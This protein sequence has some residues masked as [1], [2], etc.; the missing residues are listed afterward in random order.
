VAEEI[1]ALG[2]GFSAQSG[3]NSYGLQGS[4]LS[5]DLERGLGFFSELLWRP[6]LHEDDVARE[7]ALQL[8]DLRTRDDHPAGVAISLF[9]EGLYT[10]HPYRLEQEGTT[11][12]VASLESAQLRAH[13]ERHYGTAGLVIAAAGDVDP[14]QLRTLLEP[15]LAAARAGAAVGDDPPHDPP[16]PGVVQRHRSLPRRQAHLVYGFRGTTLD[17]PDRA[18]A[19]LLAAVLGGQGGRLFADLRDKQSLAYS[20]SAFSGEGLAPGHFAVYIGTSPD[21]VAAAREGIQRHLQRLC[22]DRVPMAEL[23]RARRQLVGGHVRGLQRQATRAGVMAL[24]ACY[25][26]GADFHLGQEARLQAVTPASLQ[27]AAQRL[28]DFDRR[29][30]ALVSPEAQGA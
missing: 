30:E 15:H 16:P 5:A 9:L 27:E 2:G 19:Q 20:V 1:D 18:A 29:V 22:D 14:E 26:L 11:A 7:R 23:E 10:A 8:E 4:F 12:V 6:A 28:F 21:K 25:G 13:L 3:R 24:D 17:A